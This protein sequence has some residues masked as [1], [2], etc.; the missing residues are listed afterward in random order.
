MNTAFKYIHVFAVVV[1]QNTD[2]SLADEGL[3][4]LRP[5]REILSHPPGAHSGPKDIVYFSLTRH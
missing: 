2:M 5:P 1:Y 3:E 4:R